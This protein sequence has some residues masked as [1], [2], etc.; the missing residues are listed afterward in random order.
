MD[1]MH[2]YDDEADAL[3]RAIVAYARGRIASPQP[4]DG[5][6]AGED[7]T[8][9]AG[10]TITA[11]GMGGDE[12]LRIWSEIL[13]PATISTDHPSSMAFVPGA[14]TK[15]SVLFDLVVGSSSTIAAG[16]IDGAGAIWAE[17]QA[18][19]WLADLAGYPP[20]AGGVFVSGGS[21][22]NL[23][24]LVTARAAASQRLGSRPDGGW[25][26]ALAESAHSS[27][28]TAA[29]VMDVEVL[30][31][32][33]DD[34]GRLEGPALRAALDVL[35]PAERHSVFAVVASAGATNA[36]TVD[37][38]AGVADVCETNDL[39]M[40]VDGAYGG[41]GLVAPSVRALY[42]GI[43]RA[44]SFIVD[45]HKWL[46]APYDCCALLYRDPERARGVFRQEAGYLDTVNQE[47]AAWSEW[48]PADF[49]YHLTRRARGL[50]FWFSLATY[51]TDAYRDA[52]EGVLALTRQTA[53]EIRDRDG[54]ELLLDPD[55]SVV[56]FRRTGWNDDDYEAWWRRILDAQIAFVQPTTF[57]GEK[58]ARLCFVNPR[59]TMDHVRAVLGT[60]GS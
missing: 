54:L 27:I 59:T 5:S 10:D 41:A 39:W 14:P 55:L 47:G 34:R 52:V 44:D 45:P 50:P 37:D 8:R 15:A 21:A 2:R 3:S 33:G 23:S 29:R 48:N 40:H 46:F 53:Q 57:R 31:V 56:L 35:G 58:V 24:A 9:R 1:Q 20:E 25:R 19:R 12:A 13:A 42:D 6:A 60:M 18:L 4:L 22:G 49:A 32:A 36:G 51:G 43:E 7:L 17:N 30:R 26:V 38:L 28:V 11:D 16:W